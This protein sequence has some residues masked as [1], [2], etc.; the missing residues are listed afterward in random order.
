MHHLGPTD[1][2]R[3][4]VLGMGAQQD[5]LRFARAIASHLTIPRAAVRASV[6][7]EHGEGMVPLW[8]SVYVVDDQDEMRSRLDSLRAVYAT[9][10]IKT[11]SIQSLR[12]QIEALL[13]SCEV[14]R[15]YL[16]LQSAS[17][18]VFRAVLFCRLRLRASERANFV[19]IFRLTHL[20]ANPFAVSTA[21]PPGAS[22]TFCSRRATSD[23]DE[24]NYKSDPNTKRMIRP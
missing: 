7:G 15:A 4:R 5:S 22:V 23:H 9:D 16:L 12:L 24:V 14:E 20:R 2:R 21:T 17:P 1:T 6:G 18:D 11:G 10:S 19:A 8:S 13:Q 3:T